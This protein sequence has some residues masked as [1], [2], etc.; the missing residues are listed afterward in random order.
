MNLKI[1]TLKGPDEP[2]TDLDVV[3]I[4]LYNLVYE[5]IETGSSKGIIISEGNPNQRKV[6]WKKVMSISHMLE[7][8][9]MCRKLHGGGTCGECCNWESISEVS[10]HLGYCK[11]KDKKHIHKL[12]SCKLFSK[13]V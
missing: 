3:F 4:A 12:S 13:K 5:K 1:G 2:I 8:Y 9:F 6:S 10:P 11:V 7:D